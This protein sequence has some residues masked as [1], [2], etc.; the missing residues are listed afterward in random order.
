MVFP[1]PGVNACAAPKPN[2]ANIA[3]R[4]KPGGISAR[5]KN[6]ERKSFRTRVPAGADCALTVD[7]SG[8]RFAAGCAIGGTLADLL[9]A[10]LLLAGLL[11]AGL[12]LAF[13]LLMGALPTAAIGVHTSS[14]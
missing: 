3:K 1:C 8:V 2:A 6:L 9:L 5:R 4:I 14:A 11:L 10:G 7:G 12:L 13:S